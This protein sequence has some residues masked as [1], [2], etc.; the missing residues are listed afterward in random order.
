MR[1]RGPID[2]VLVH[3]TTQAPS[4]WERLA[5][6]LGLLGHV[7]HLVDLAVVPADSSA[8]VF[9]ASVAD[10]VDAR[11]PI[12]VAHSGA[13]L[14]I[15]AI[16]VAIGARHQI[17]LA[18]AIPDGQ[19]SL[20][21]ELQHH[22]DA[23]FNPDWI[24]R[25]PTSNVTD[26]REFL[27][28]DCD[29][30]TTEWALTSLRGFHPALVYDEPVPLDTSTPATVVVPDADRTM[31]PAWMKQAARD[32]LGIVATPIGGGHCPHVSRPEQFAALI[33]RLAL[34]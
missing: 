27:F 31:R 29:E 3:G 13:G 11:H 5:L 8:A 15:G 23:M 18:A 6:H 26:A 16:A 10:Q 32:R 24:G 34:S 1:Q 21:T 7:A 4:G 22:A 2:V 33:D 12:V 9:A 17:F 20:M 19:Q 30:P 25:D 28:H 14:L